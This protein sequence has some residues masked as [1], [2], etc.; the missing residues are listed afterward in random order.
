MLSNVLVRHNLRILMLSNV[1][2]RHNLRI[3]V[4]ILKLVRAI[5]KSSG[6]S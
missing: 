5:G 6:G 2:V 4:I 1:L 3:G